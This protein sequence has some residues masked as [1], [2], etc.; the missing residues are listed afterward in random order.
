MPNR[1]LRDI[2]DSEKV[3]S[4]SAQAEVL[5]YRLM[6]KADDYG[7]FHAKPS[8][9]KAALFPLRLD[10]IR[11]AEISRW[12][13]ECEK[14]GLIVFYDAESKPFLVIVNFGQRMRNMKKRFPSPPD[15]ILQLAATR[16]NSR[17]ETKPKLETETRNENPK[18]EDAD[19]KFIRQF[20]AIKEKIMQDEMFRA[21]AGKMYLADELY[22]FAV[23]EFF[24]KKMNTR[25]FITDKLTEESNCRRNLMY[26]LSKN[27]TRIE[28]EFKYGNNGTEVKHDHGKIEVD[29]SL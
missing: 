19:E 27:Y 8:L 24:R 13:A 10:S 18:S 15:E 1:I 2:T 6:M 20:V 16:G 14:A 29:I 9:I 12:L 4:L 3:N 7:V 25:E 23:D 11:E 5:F 22:R 17:P 26:W 28:K 21:D